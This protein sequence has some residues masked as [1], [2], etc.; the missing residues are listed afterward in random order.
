MMKKYTLGFYLAAALLATTA[1]SND[2][3]P[4]A[5]NPPV[6][7]DDDWVAP[8]GRVVVQLG[9][10]SSAMASTS[11]TRGTGDGPLNEAADMYNKHIGVFALAKDGVDLTPDGGGDWSTNSRYECL[12]LNVKGLW[13]DT[14]SSDPV[15]QKSGAKKISLFNP[16]GTQAGAVYYYP[17]EQG[18]NY[19][20]Y[21]YYPYQTSFE[22]KEQTATVDITIDGSHDIIWSKAEAQDISSSQ[23]FEN[24]VDLKG[25]NANYIRKIK[26]HNE[27]VAEKEMTNYFA[28]VPNL[29][30]D[31]KLAQLKFYIVASDDQSPED[32]ADTKELRV[33]GIKLKDVHTKATLDITTGHITWSNPTDIDMH[34]MGGWTNAG[35]VA[36][37]TGA[38][39]YK[40]IPQENTAPE[41][42]GV[43]MVEAGLS[44]Y[45]VEL[46]IAGADDATNTPQTVEVTVQ[47]GGGKTFE[48]GKYY[49]VKIALYAMQKVEVDAT[50]NK[51]QQG[52]EIVVPV[53]GEE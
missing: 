31:H 48:A 19:T 12:L 28:Y 49:D 22:V 53:G 41:A 10:Y 30:F 5:D 8:D 44:S 51:W 45:T 42:A 16:G 21:G 13:T 33:T 25:Y 26:H 34:V 37:G 29:V 4:V 14:E 15:N 6:V 2:D 32:I 38:D 35:N 39:D 24:N 9:G 43:A 3:G 23:L 52:S 17:I 46:Q 50:L 18:L 20:F 1:C 36:E 47:L 11:V 40:F 7:T 27:I